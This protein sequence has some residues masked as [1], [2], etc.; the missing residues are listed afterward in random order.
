MMYH[1][2]CPRPP[3]TI[4]RLNIGPSELELLGLEVAVPSGICAYIRFRGFK[5]HH[6]HPHHCF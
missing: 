2:R 4:A 5:K 3:G 1:S 6:R